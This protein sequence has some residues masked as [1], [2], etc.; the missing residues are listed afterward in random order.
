MKVGKSPWNWWNSPF[1]EQRSP[2]LYQIRQVKA[3]SQGRTGSSSIFPKTSQLD[4]RNV[5]IPIQLARIANAKRKCKETTKE[6][7]LCQGEACNVLIPTTETFRKFQTHWA[8]EHTLVKH[9]TQ[10]ETS[11]CYD[12]DPN[13]FLVQCQRYTVLYQSSDRAQLNIITDEN[14]HWIFIFFN[15]IIYETTCV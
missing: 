6:R 8:A 14:T 2:Q 13:L 1:Q 7:I 5:S 9:V 4:D 3:K 10:T 15:E 11:R 12:S